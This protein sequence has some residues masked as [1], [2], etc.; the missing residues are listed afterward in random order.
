MDSMIFGEGADN[1]MVQ[2]ILELAL[3]PIPFL[4]FALAWIPVF[5][6]LPGYISSWAIWILLEIA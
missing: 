5:G 6:W 3:S 1:L 4:G 2:Q